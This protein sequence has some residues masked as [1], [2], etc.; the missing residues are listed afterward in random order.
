[1]SLGDSKQWLQ[2]RVI[3]LMRNHRAFAF[4]R[5]HERRAWPVTFRT[6]IKQAAEKAYERRQD[7]AE[8]GEE[9]KFIVSRPR[10]L[11]HFLTQLM[12]SAMVLQQPVSEH[13]K[14]LCAQP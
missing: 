1:M 10:I 14:H 13:S 5:F 7:K 12:A 2:Y 11:S 6:S 4:F 3:H 9:A 8:D